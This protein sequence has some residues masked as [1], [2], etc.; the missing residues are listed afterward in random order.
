MFAISGALAEYIWSCISRINSVL[1]PLGVPIRVIGHMLDQAGSQGV[2]DNIT[3]DGNQLFVFA[4][5]MIV[6]SRLP[7]SAAPTNFAVQN[8]RAAR[9]EAFH[10][11]TQFKLTQLKE[12]VNV[13]RHYDPA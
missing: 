1:Q 9:F 7:E 13:I 11:G 10:D 2:G 4:Q 5:G 12:Q 8:N 6:E 3:C